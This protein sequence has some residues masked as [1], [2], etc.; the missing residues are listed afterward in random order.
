MSTTAASS[1]SS[2][3]VGSTARAIFATI[4]FV[5]WVAGTIVWV[6]SMA[7]YAADGHPSAAIMAIAAI[8]L[9]ILLAGMEGLEIAATD[10]WEALWPD[11][12]KSHLAGW[13]A[14]R[15]LFVALIAVTTTQL[16]EPHHLIVPFTSVRL[17]S[18]LTLKVF[19]LVWLTLA[20]LWFAQILPKH[21]AAMNADRYLG[22]LR[23]M[24]F[25]VVAVVDK[26]GVT[27]P[28][29]RSA[30]VVEHS[31]SWHPK[32]GEV[33]EAPVHETSLGSAWRELIPEERGRTP[34]PRDRSSGLRDG[35]SLE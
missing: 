22:H 27:L 26:S 20:I 13:L 34:G 7:D 19:D 17:D 29:K 16:A 24:L 32:D 30:M 15:Q 18:A 31:L 4:L 1:T 11:G 25:P 33:L 3:R 14:A 23:G 35:E 28:G 5:A 8:L 9:L 6:A 12:N 2:S 10:R 21:M